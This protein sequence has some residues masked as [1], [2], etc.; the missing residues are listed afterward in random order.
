MIYT[1]LTCKAMKYAYDAHHGQLDGLTVRHGQRP[2]IAETHRT[3]VYVRFASGS[4]SAGTEH[5]GFGL[6][7]DMRLK[8]YSIFE[9]HVAY[10]TILNMPYTIFFCAPVFAPPR[11]SARSSF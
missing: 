3:Y 7:L 9:F 8:T 4:Q 1:A 5:L 2:G 10:Y 11:P 6:Q